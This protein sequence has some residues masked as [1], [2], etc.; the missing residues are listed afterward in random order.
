[1]PIAALS[2]MTHGQEADLFVLLTAKEELTTRDGKP[3]FKV[4]FR[5]HA[6]EV[7]FPIWQDSPWG[8]D[9][10]EAWQPGTFYK[11]RAVYRETSYGPQLDLRKI[12]AVCAADETDG[13]SPAL[14]LPQTRFDAQ[15]MFAE[16]LAIARERIDGRG[17]ARAG[18]RHPASQSGRAVDAAGRHAQSPRLHRRMA[19][20]RAERHAHQ[21]LLRRQVR[22][23]LPG[24]EAAAEQRAG[25]RGGDPAR[26]R[27]AARDCRAADRRRVYGRR[28]PDWPHPAG[29]RHR[30]RSGRRLAR[31]TP[32]CNCAWSTSSWRISGC[33]SG[34]RP[35]RR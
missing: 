28:Q 35:S 26:H 18:R 33:P 10:R 9:C 12:R 14:C 2:E 3:Y 4:T 27:Q 30:A 5:D 34:D 6:R 17:I 25:G 31:S 20:A 15:A 32:S 1:M 16:L 29:A 19:G 11:V 7:A 8:A 21:R 22:R 13:F 24:D 23:L